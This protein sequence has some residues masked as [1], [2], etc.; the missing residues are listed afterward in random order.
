MLSKAI[1]L[2]IKGY[3]YCISPMLGPHCRFTPTCSQY[4]KDAIQQHGALK[5][6]TLAIKRICK[7]HPFHCGG[8]DPVPKKKVDQH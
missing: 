1:I 3:Q 8:I 4:A 2:L 6:T 7:C 5:G